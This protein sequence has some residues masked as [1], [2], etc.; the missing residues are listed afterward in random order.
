LLAEWISGQSTAPVH[1]TF[2]PPETSGVFFSHI[3]QVRRS[4]AVPSPLSTN[5]GVGWFHVQDSPAGQFESNL[6]VP[7][8]VEQTPGVQVEA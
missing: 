8:L 6:Q 5:L 3:R 7:P 1:C 4:V 2:A